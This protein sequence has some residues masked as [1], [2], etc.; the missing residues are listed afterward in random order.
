MSEPLPKRPR[1]GAAGLLDV[2]Y[3]F[4][5]Q[6]TNG[7]LSWPTETGAM[8][9]LCRDIDSRVLEQLCQHVYSHKISTHVRERTRLAHAARIGD[10]ARVTVLLGHGSHADAGT[11]CALAWA[12]GC[13]HTAAARKLLAVGAS[14]PRCLCALALHSH[15]FK[16]PPL[17]D[18]HAAARSALI[19]ELCANP[20]AV[21][22]ASDALHL[23]V[24][25]AIP[26]LVSRHI[27]DAEA[28]YDGSEDSK[29]DAWEWLV[30]LH[31][32]CSAGYKEVLLLLAARPA[33]FEFDGWFGI[34][35][36][37]DDK[38]LLQDLCA[39]DPEYNESEAL[40]AACG[41]GDLAFVK[42]LLARDGHARGDYFPPDDRQ[43]IV[44]FFRGWQPWE[45]DRPSLFAAAQN[46]HVDVVD[47]I[48]RWLR[49]H[50]DHADPDQS[51]M[52]AV[53]CGL[54]LEAERLIS[55]NGID[56]DEKPESLMFSY[57]SYLC[58][59]CD[60]ADV[61]MVRMLLEEGADPNVTFD[62]HYPM[63][64]AASSCGIL[65]SRW[66]PK[67]AEDEHN[68][69]ETIVCL[70][71]SK[72]AVLGPS[73]QFRQFEDAYDIA[74]ALVARLSTG[75]VGCCRNDALPGDIAT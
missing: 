57:D 24:E 35:A 36:D 37:L 12:T 48:L 52:A 29:S 15:D 49:V 50:P 7:Q 61:E 68:R 64:H 60:R 53:G 45:F 58:L 70:L 75:E 59:A 31:W 73:P 13:G 71:I 18:S 56:V 72:G 11:V 3:I 2:A 65:R 5:A 34:V 26:S 67:P 38:R 62:R 10:D 54:V 8:L 46:G 19:E 42:S 33:L 63:F 22:S 74:R 6:K 30:C 17:S 43:D 41:V 66:T 27:D 69:R 28:A 20:S 40:F 51:L 25:Y 47:Y 16:Y 9:A 32:G 44:L 55:G 1:Y 4:A 39:I 21:T 23:G 14:I